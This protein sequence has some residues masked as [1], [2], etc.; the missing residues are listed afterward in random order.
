MHTV[1]NQK[2]IVNTIKVTQN[3]IAYV[4]VE[5]LFKNKK[6]VKELMSKF[7]SFH[8]KRMFNRVVD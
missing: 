1:K 8:K 7:D 4:P 2:T 5:E 3:G 6:E